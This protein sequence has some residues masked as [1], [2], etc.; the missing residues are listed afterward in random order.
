MSGNIKVTGKTGTRDITITSSVPDLVLWLNQYNGKGSDPLFP[1]NNVTGR[2]S[3]RA[4]QTIF[5]K[6]VK[7][8]GIKTE[9]K[10]VNVHSIRH[11]RLSELAN[12]KVPEMHL[13]EFAGW[14]RNSE[15]PSV[16]IHP[17]K[18]DVKLSILQA[19]GIS[20][21]EA[22]EI[23]E[24]QIDMKPILCTFCNTYNPYNAKRCHCGAALNY[25]AILEDQRKQEARDVEL[26]ER[27]LKA[28]EANQQKINT[29]CGETE[30]EDFD[31]EDMPEDT[32]KNI[33]EGLQGLDKISYEDMPETNEELK[34]R[35]RNENKKE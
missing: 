14:T 21:E 29:W 19:A 12:Q 4:V 20:V 22:E 16:Y 23:P 18:K 13:R 34:N 15:M 3:V 7:E 35:L 6:L 31:F 27:A 9:G 1:G 28:F 30:P 2:L 24:I 5:A 10:K 11:G 26:I 17:T 8:V 32:R 33:P 25:E